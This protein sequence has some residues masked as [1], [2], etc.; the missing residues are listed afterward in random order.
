MYFSM[1]SSLSC[2]VYLSS[3][4]HLFGSQYYDQLWELLSCEGRAWTLTAS[5]VILGYASASRN[6]KWPPSM[7]Q[8]Q[9]LAKLPLIL[10]SL[11]LDFRQRVNMNWLILK[12]NRIIY[13][14][15]LLCTLSI[16]WLLLKLIQIFCKFV[17]TVHPKHQ[18]VA[19]QTQ[20]DHL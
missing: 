16:N 8:I 9:T 20:A 6:E 19:S 15:L 14:Y 13:R 3:L 1:V 18:L 11:L 12:L 2:K 10:H 4:G 7:M 17:F 5:P